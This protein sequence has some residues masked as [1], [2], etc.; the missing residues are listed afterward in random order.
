MS[1]TAELSSD[2]AVALPEMGGA[3]DAR[4]LKDVLMVFSSTIR[5]LSREESRRRRD[6]FPPR[7]PPD[8]F[9]CASRGA[10]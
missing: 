9:Q 3:A 8:F 10:N 5:S 2:V 7:H 4:D 6:R 1:V